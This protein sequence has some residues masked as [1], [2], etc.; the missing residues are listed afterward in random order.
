MKQSRIDAVGAARIL[1]ALSIA[2]GLAL[3]AVP[4]TMAEVYALP[5]RTRLLRA[6]G[7]RDVAIGVALLFRKSASVGCLLRGLSDAVDT[8]LIASEAVHRR[9]SASAVA[10]RIAG[11]LAIV[12]SAAG[13]YRALGD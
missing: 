3:A 12:A 1:G 8:G 11:A 5:H 4:T 2:S 10:L 13:L 9:R 7:V 6:I